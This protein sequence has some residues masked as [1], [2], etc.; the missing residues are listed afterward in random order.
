MVSSFCALRRVE[1]IFGWMPPPAPASKKKQLNLRELAMVCGL[2][3][4]TT[5]KYISLLEK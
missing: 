2:S 3:R 1:W 5:Y 4:T